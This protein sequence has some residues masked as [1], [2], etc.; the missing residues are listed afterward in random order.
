MTKIG[1]LGASGYTG[2]ELIRILLNSKQVKISAITSEKY[3]RTNISDIFPFFKGRLDLIYETLSPE[4]ISEKCDFVFSAL[5]HK[6]SMSVIPS[7]LKAGKKAVDLSADY[8]LKSPDIYK[9]WYKEE[10][11]SPELLGSAIYGIPELKRKKIKAASL[12][13]NPGCYPTSVILALAP[14]IK[15]NIINT[16]SIII[17][18][19]SGVTGAGRKVEEALLFAE[20]NENFKSYSLASHRHTPEIEQEI[21]EI[22]GK[23]IKITFVPHLLPVNRGILSTIYSDLI[24]DLTSDKI[25]KIYENFYKGERF[26]RIMGHGK[27]PQLRSVLGSNYCD[28]GFQIDRRTKRIIVIS[29]IDN[30]VKG[31]AGQAVQNMNI[32]LGFEEYAG[33]EDIGFFP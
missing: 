5:P 26:I 7:L 21:S 20:C 6:T 4:V 11:T 16:D 12:V 19:K 33:L 30:L 13:A 22:A 1:V 15:E 24:S 29:A 14:L 32:M 18:S 28:I 9:E 8:R 25:L 17:D 10:H 31:A 3:T 2:L 27:S 23:K